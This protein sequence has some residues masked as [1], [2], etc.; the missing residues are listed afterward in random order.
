MKFQKVSMFQENEKK[1]EANTQIVKTY[2]YDNPFKALAIKQLLFVLGCLVFVLAL[3]SYVLDV[4]FHEGQGIFPYGFSLISIVGILST[5]LLPSELFRNR[6]VVINYPL[7]K[8]SSWHANG[9]P[10]RFV[11]I[12]GLVILNLGA[13]LAIAFLAPDNLEAWKCHITISW[14]QVAIYAV[15]S[16]IMIYIVL[17]QHFLNRKEFHIKEKPAAEAGYVA[18]DLIRELSPFSWIFLVLLLIMMFFITLLI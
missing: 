6:D 1:E 4:V 10:K 12:M 14:I 13:R 3:A 18:R 2:D 11:I 7:N 15:S 8:V 17:R 9:C 5:I 16:I